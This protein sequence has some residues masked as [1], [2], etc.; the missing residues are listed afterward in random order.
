VLCVTCCNRSRNAQLVPGQAGVVCAFRVV[1]VT[2]HHLSHT[3]LISDY[4]NG[5]VLM[6]DLSSINQQ[7][8]SMLRVV[9]NLSILV[10]YACGRRI[11]FSSS[12]N[13]FLFILSSILFYTIQR[14][15]VSKF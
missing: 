5:V 13:T 10:W 12:L 1:N 11:E 8:N 6:S 3:T 2:L 7:Q 9:S 14:I 4:E 15:T